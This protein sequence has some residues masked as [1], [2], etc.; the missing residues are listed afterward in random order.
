MRMMKTRL[1]ATF[2]EGM[3]YEKTD[4]E[5]IKI[6]VSGCQREYIEKLYGRT[7]CVPEHTVHNVQYTIYTKMKYEF[8]IF[9]SEV[10]VS[11]NCFLAVKR[12]HFPHSIN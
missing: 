3:T 1:K 8:E 6:Q 7:L 11:I 2:A 9:K 4:W 10:E 12:K 5:S